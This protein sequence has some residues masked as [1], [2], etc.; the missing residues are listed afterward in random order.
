MKINVDT[1]TFNAVDARYVRMQG[2]KRA[3]PYG[4]SIW[5]FE[6]YTA[7]GSQSG[8]GSESGGNQ[9]GG[10]QT[11]GDYRQLQ[12][13]GAD[14]SGAENAAMAASNAIDGNVGTRWSSNFDDNAWITFDLGGTYSVDKVELN[15]EAAYG[16]SYNVLVSTNGVN[17]TIVKTLTGMHGGVDTITFNAVNARYVNCIIN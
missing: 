11:G 8:S 16:E 13:T 9:G 1:I 10:S 14:A 5:E 17:Y 2:V 4:Y 15:W 6:V 7:G 3:L 12:I